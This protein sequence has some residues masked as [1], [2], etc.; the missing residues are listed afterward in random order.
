MSSAARRK[1]KT[2]EKMEQQTDFKGLNK[3]VRKQKIVDTAVRIFHEKGY[4][5]ATL[6]DVAKE[7]GLTKAALYHYVLSKEDLLSIIYILALENFFANAYEI[8]ERNLAPTEKL[9][10]L[11]RHHIKHIIIENVPMFAVFFSE[12]NQLPEKDFQKIREEKRK[13]TR[14]VEG[15]IET[16]IAQGHFQP[17]DARLQAYA[18]IGMCNW[19]YKWYKPDESPYAPDEIADHF[20]ALLENGYLRAQ[21]QDGRTVVADSMP[22]KRELFE[23]LKTETAT[24]SNLIEELEKFV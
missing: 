13:Y 14:I 7:L 19:L 20:I 23:T 22:R 8:G 24:L 21:G 10:L 2:G 3:S 18:I 1:D 12:E 16:G 9:R 6:D 17:T 4:H 5:A 11:I 15:I